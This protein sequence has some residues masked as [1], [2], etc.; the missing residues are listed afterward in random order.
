MRLSPRRSEWAAAALV[1]TVAVLAVTSSLQGAPPDPPTPVTRRDVAALLAQ[2]ARPDS[3]PHP[4]DNAYTP[5]RRALGKLL[6]FDPR[7]S[8]GGD[9][10]CATC[11]DPARS[12]GDGRARAV[13]ATRQPLGRRTPTVLNTAYASTLFWD[14]RAES[15][16]QQALGPIEA[17]GEM[18][19]PLPRMVARV[20]ALQG[21]RALFR[22]AYG[23]DSVTAELVGRAIAQFERTVNSTPAPFDRWAAGDDRAIGESAKRGFVLF[24]GKANCASCH[25]GWR[26]TD[27]SFHDIGVP[28]TDSGR[29]RV[30]P[31][32]EVT[33]FAFKTPTLRNAVER[34]PYMHDGS[35]RS[36]EEVIDLYDRGGRVRRPSLSP[37]IR[38]LGLT[39]AERRDLVAFL[40]TLSSRDTVTV[41]AR[42]PR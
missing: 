36:L 5:A 11:H 6:F 30:V 2:Y 28:G 34:A 3:V 29:A 21:Y 37:L 39:P 9:I 19:L 32:I 18:G 7:L 8:G 17:A 42:L 41:P 40:R 16:E 22:R 38:P 27:D 14:G 31:G 1:C 26:F 4:A 25:G 12:Y 10:S 24:N 33:E 13:G 23:A 35:E 20:N 15:L